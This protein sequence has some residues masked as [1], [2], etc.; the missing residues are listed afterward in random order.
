VEAA[1][2]VGPHRHHPAATQLGFELP[3]DRL[4][5][6]ELRHATSVAAGGVTPGPPPGQ[7]VVALEKVKRS[8]ARAGAR[9]AP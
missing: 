8:M 2:R 5:L 1:L 6:G 7:N 9:A 4:D 3:A